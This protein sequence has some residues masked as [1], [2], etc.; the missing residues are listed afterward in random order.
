V[1]TLLALI[2]DNFGNVRGL[3]TSGGLVLL[4]AAEVNTRAVVE[5]SI[6]VILGNH[7]IEIPGALVDRTSPLPA[8]PIENPIPASLPPAPPVVVGVLVPSA[9]LVDG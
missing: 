2:E 6:A 9:D 4:D 1:K 7:G 8:V 5:S 3:E